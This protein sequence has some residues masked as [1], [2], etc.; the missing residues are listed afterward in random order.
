MSIISL[1]SLIGI[2]VVMPL[3]VRSRLKAEQKTKER[4]DDSYHVMEANTSEFGYS[5]SYLIPKDR[6]E[7]A[8]IF[9]PDSAKTPQTKDTKSRS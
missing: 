6:D 8:K 3:L 7:Y 9:V 5:H 4:N 2:F 1:V